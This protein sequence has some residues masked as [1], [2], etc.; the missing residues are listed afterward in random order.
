MRGVFQRFR[1][2]LIRGPDYITTY[3][4][5]AVLHS[6]HNPYVSLSK[7]ARVKS[8]QRTGQGRHR[9]G[10]L[11]AKVS[12]FPAVNQALIQ[13][14]VRLQHLPESGNKCNKQLARNSST[15]G[16]QTKTRCGSG[17][18]KSGSRAENRKESS[19]PPD[20]GFGCPENRNQ[21]N[22][23]LAGSKKFMNKTKK[24]MNRKKEANKKIKYSSTFSFRQL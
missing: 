18:L 14:S 24:F 10:N 23:S 15:R 19:Q 16:E 7:Y 6:S 1:L 17:E 13:S 11:H 2:A 8:K 9:S 3:I 4:Y 22:G 5:Y 12:L 20:T 21:A